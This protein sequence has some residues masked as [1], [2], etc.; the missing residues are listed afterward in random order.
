MGQFE[1]EGIILKTYSLAEADKIVLLLTEKNGLMR[2]VA[3]GAKR[4]K[5]KFGG[6]LEPFS[7]VMAELYQKEEKELV[8]IRNL[9]L[10]K[11]F[12]TQASNPLILQ[13]LA[14]LS[15]LLIE[16]S[17]P[18]DPNERVYNM[19]KICFETIVERQEMTD[20]IVLYFEF[21]LLSLG[22][23]LP[24]WERCNICE[25][26]FT[27]SENSNL[28]M[29]FHLICDRCRK[30]QGN[31]IVDSEM[32]EMFLRARIFSP[33]RFI[34]NFGNKNDLIKNLSV[35]LKRIINQILNREIVSQ[36]FMISASQP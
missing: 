1:T 9:E 34:E 12:F 24:N 33:K 11:S 6:N 10:Q 27:E 31:Q 19:A 3:K 25:N 17:P 32:R 5:S 8:S 23:Y 4:L 13:K 14:Y 35:I 2:G 36:K 18:H 15:E 20:L 16:F 21:W 7:V 28:Q 22:G 26:E 29:N 30:S